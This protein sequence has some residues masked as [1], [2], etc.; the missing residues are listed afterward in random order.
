MQPLAPWHPSNVVL[1]ATRRRFKEAGVRGVGFIKDY[2]LA[3]TRLADISIVGSPDPLYKS[4][5]IAV[6]EITHVIANAEHYFGVNKDQNVMMRGDGD[7]G[8][9]SNPEMITDMK[10]LWNWSSPAFEDDPGFGSQIERIR[11]SFYMQKK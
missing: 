7:G 4:R 5:Y 1:A 10:R 6:H 2:T 11:Q 9:T 8:N 3:R